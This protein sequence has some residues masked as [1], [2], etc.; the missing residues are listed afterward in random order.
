M[1]VSQHN[2]PLQARTS[3]NPVHRGALLIFLCGLLCFLGIITY[4]A[5]A[6]TQNLT[7]SGH[8]VASAHDS[9]KQPVA[10]ANRNH[11]QAVKPQPTP[12][13]TPVVP[14]SVPQNIGKPL[15]HAVF[16]GNTKLPEI[17]LTFDDGPNPVYTRQ[18]LTVLNAY[19]V[20]AT[21][22]DVGYLVK[23][24]PD[25]VRQ[26]FLQGNIIGNH[27]WSHPDLTRF[28]VAGITSQLVSTSDAIQSVTGT[29]PVLFRPP[30]GSFNA[31]VI[32][33]ATQLNLTA[34]LWNDESRDWATPGVNVIVS[35]ILNLAHNGSIILL[36]DGGGFRTQTVAA[37]PIIIAALHQ[38]GFTFVTVPQLL[39]DMTT[40][41]SSSRVTPTTGSHNSTAFMPDLLT[42][43]KRE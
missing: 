31:T 26:E 42:A 25:I 11:Q 2:N 12:Q 33:Q 15:G 30:Y 43:W 41:E 24:Y 22:F 28:S 38:R 3:G 8:P 1:H 4:N 13:K 34:I 23:D 40:P 27:S 7:A 16:Y 5:E 18:I 19:N 29:R 37:L 36:H 20:K 14:T 6:S 39:L 10:T 32:A 35:R 21:F 9:R 17:A